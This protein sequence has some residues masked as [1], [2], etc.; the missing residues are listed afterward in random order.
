M[1]LCA[2]HFNKT[3]LAVHQILWMCFPNP[4]I[5]LKILLLHLKWK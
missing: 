4:H 3:S 1:M 5:H 2:V